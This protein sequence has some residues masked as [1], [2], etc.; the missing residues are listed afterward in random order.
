MQLSISS[1]RVVIWIYSTLTQI[2][3]IVQL[4]PKILKLSSCCWIM[5]FQ[6]TSRINMDISRLI[7]FKIRRLERFSK[8]PKMIKLTTSFHS[9]LKR[10]SCSLSS[11]SII[12]MKRVK[13]LWESWFSKIT[14]NNSKTML[15]HSMGL[16]LKIYYQLLNMD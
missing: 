3:C 12:R 15:M 1:N 16:F 5:E 8:K 13:F 11:T 7:L 2:L 10:I 4:C 14:S 6:S 9:W